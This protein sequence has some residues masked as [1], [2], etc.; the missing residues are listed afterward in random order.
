[1]NLKTTSAISRT[2]ILLGI[3]TRLDYMDYDKFEDLNIF[4]AV[5]IKLTALEKHI[6][7]DDYI[8]TMIDDTLRIIEKLSYKY[9][10]CMENEEDIYYDAIVKLLL[11]NDYK[12]G[13][14]E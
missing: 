5:Q 13:E 2:R 6:E 1:M 14:Y 10:G 12:I 3:K 7:R 8:F 11:D 9:K 4:I